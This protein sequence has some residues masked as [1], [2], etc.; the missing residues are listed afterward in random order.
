MGDGWQTVWNE[1]VEG[2]EPFETVQIQGQGQ[3]QTSDSLLTSQLNEQI[4]EQNRKIEFYRKSLTDK[5]V[6]FYILYFCILYF[7]VLYFKFYIF[8]FYMFLYYIY[9]CITEN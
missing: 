7:Y 2:D 8:V 6:R 4:A 3:K 1:E 9:I 5:E